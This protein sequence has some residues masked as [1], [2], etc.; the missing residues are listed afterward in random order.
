MKYVKVGEFQQE[1]LDKPHE[2]QP[3]EFFTKSHLE[4]IDLLL[5]MVREEY[6]NKFQ[7]YISDLLA[8]YTSF[9]KR[10]NLKNYSIP[11]E[12][13][14]GKNVIKESTQLAE[15]ILNYYLS[16]LKITD[17]QDWI[18]GKIKTPQ[19]NFYRAF[20][21]PRYQNV[22]TLIK[23]LGREEGVK[24]YKKYVSMFFIH[25]GKTEREEEFT[26]L[27]DHYERASRQESTPSDWVTI[28]GLMDNG[29]Y[30]YMNQN[31]LWV[32]SLPEIE[33]KELMYLICCYGDYQ[34]ALRYYNKHVILTMEHTIAQ[35]DL[36][37]SRM[38]H[39]TRED[40][41]LRHPESE[42]WDKLNNEFP[43]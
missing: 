34:S 14:E 24:L 10:S 15:L 9:L 1:A 40:W 22:K 32:E 39:D 8:N 4:R 12:L 41:D 7:E 23:T 20:L 19:R 17:N 18:D 25:L 16:L 28:R 35:G 38:L 33:D 42:F 30:F 29:K 21:L 6:P 31:C 13:L 26:N 27:R 3:K 43:L 11:T 5:T 37:C 36:Y 2:L